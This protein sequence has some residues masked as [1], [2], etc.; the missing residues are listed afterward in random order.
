MGAVGPYTRACCTS[1]AF[2]QA[3]A[4][5]RV[6]F[7]KVTQALNFFAVKEGGAINKMKA[8]KLIWLAD[9]L[10]LRKHGRL[11]TNDQYFAMRFGPVASNSINLA[12]A[13]VWADATALDYRNEFLTSTDDNTY[14]STTDVDTKQFSQSEREAIQLV[15][16]AYGHLDQWK[17]SDLSHL[18]PEWLKFEKELEA[19]PNARF[20]IDILDF[21]KPGTLKQ[22]PLF[23]QSDEYLAIAKALHAD[24]VK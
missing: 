7:R 20:E 8:I 1:F 4:P 14:R 6:P 22:D 9:R 5:K 23:A 12:Q 21:F 11:I 2:V 24:A 19:H 3:K 17:L 15:F 18:Y 13:S 16:D 10:H